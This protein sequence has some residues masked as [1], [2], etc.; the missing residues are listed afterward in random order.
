MHRMGATLPQEDVAIT[1]MEF[2]SMVFEAAFR[3]PSY[4]RWFHE[5]ADLAPAYALHRK[6]LQALQSRCPAPR[7]VLKTPGHLWALDAFLAEYPDACLVQTHRDP[8]SV[9]SS[10][11]SLCTTLRALASETVEPSEIAR[12]WQDLNAIAYDA[13]VD[14]RETG[15]ISE[16]QIIDIHFAE[17]MSDPFAAIRRI[18]DKF[19][20][21]YTDEA[22]TRMRGY[23]ASHSDEQH[24][25]HRHRFEDTGLDVGEARERVKR[26]QEYFDVPSEIR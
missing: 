7:W 21:E 13:C 16:D 14:M 11:T 3:L 25:K 6:T 22:D 15:R 10:L 20:V 18:Y 26:Y 4:T 5:E 23:L 17:F 24:G 8:L 1:S 12:E 19:G 2:T 9:L